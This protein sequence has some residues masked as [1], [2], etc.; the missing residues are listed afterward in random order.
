MPKCSKISAQCRQRVSN[1]GRIIGH[2]HFCC[3]FCCKQN[4]S[5]DD[6]SFWL[7]HSRLQ[8]KPTCSQVGFFCG[9]CKI[10][11]S[12][13]RLR[14]VLRLN[15]IIGYRFFK[16]TVKTTDSNHTMPVYPNLLRK[17]FKT[18][19]SDRWGSKFV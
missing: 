13:K 4:Y 12:V 2:G 17:L 8:E 3:C 15:G 1:L 9:S 14:D 7:S 5:K 10:R 19:I 6:H 11:V 18:P 16:R